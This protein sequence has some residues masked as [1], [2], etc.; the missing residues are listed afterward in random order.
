M[1]AVIVNVTSV[2]STTSADLEVYPT[3]SKPSR[4]TSNLNVRPRQTVPVLVLAKVGQGGQISL[5][6][7]QGSMHVVIDVVGW[8][9][10]A[11][12]YPGRTAD[13]PAGR[14]RRGFATS[15]RKVRAP[16]GRVVG[17]ADPG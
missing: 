4:R 7:S 13:E 16:Q 12:R 17:N 15:P 6:T 10:A 3:G 9:S 8:V 11:H 1:D 14:P 5:S 2:A